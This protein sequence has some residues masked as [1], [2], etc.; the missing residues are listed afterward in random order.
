MSKQQYDRLLVLVVDDNHYMR[1]I[2][3][4]MLRSIGITQ[5]RE[6]SDGAEALALCKDWRPDIIIM[7][8]IMDQLDGLETARLIRTAKDSA[9]PYVPIIMMSGHADRQTV[10]D[11]R[12][13]GINEFVVKPMTA[14]ALIDRITKLINA[15]RAW[16]KAK[17][18]TGPDR[19][20]RHPPKYTGKMRR[21]TDDPIEI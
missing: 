8:L 13:A 1:T 16:I 17:N 7:D 2:V 15:D 5:I 10:M 9:V 18:Y 21:H 11:A 3:S 6:A 4:A 19:R 12:D 20:R 14:K